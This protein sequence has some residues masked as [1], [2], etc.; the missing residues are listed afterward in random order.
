MK[1]FL[2]SGLLVFSAFLGFGQQLYFVF[3]QDTSREPFYVRMGDKSFSSSAYGHLILSKM[4]DT[5]YTMVI[6]FPQNKEPEQQF[7][8][9]IY[10]RDRGYELKKM[11]GQWELFDLQTM[12]FTKPIAMMP[13]NKSTNYSDRKSDTY[14]EL[15]AGV[16]NDTA[17]LYPSPMPA[18]V[19]SK[20]DS[21]VV[22]ARDTSLVKGVKKVNTKAVKIKNKDS[23]LIKEALA[24]KKRA[25]DSLATEMAEQRITDSVAKLSQQ[26]KARERDSIQAV[27]KASYLEK[28]NYW[29]SMNR[30]IIVENKKKVTNDDSQLIVS[31]NKTDTVANQKAD[32]AVERGLTNL[33]S[34][35]VTRYS[36]ENTIEGKLIIYIDK[37]APVSDTI[38]LVIPRL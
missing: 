25:K 37:S 16:V 21:N 3:I 6:G 17:V 31:M 7:Q 36:S 28:A 9:K 18:V 13:K 10:S 27:S 33:S 19:I 8:V 4:Q 26:V 14:S 29:D 2:L 38:R 20:P 22:K 24:Q 32:T 15:M 35:L 34:V 5:T 23:A 12:E 30:Q 11:Y 1:R